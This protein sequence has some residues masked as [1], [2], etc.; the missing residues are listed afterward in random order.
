MA[1]IYGNDSNNAL[2]GA[3]QPDDI[4]GGGGDDTL[5]GGGGADTLFGGAGA[6]TMNGGQGADTLSGG[7]GNDT[8]DGAGEA[9]VM[10]GDSLGPGNWSF[11]VYDRNFSSANGQAFTFPGSGSTLR[12]EGVTADFN[13]DRMV[14]AARGTTGDQ[15]DFGIRLTT[16]Y[17]APSSGTY[18]F[19]LTSDDGSTMEIF[20]SAGNPV[21]WSNQTTGQTGLTYL[22]NDFHQP[23]ATRAGDVT[24]QAGQSYTIV[25]RTW[26]NAGQQILG[27]TVQNPGAT[28]PTNLAGDPNITGTFGSG[29][30]SMLGSAGNDTMFG[31][32]GDDTMFGGT[33]NDSMSGGDGNDSLSGDAGNDT[34][35][36][37][38]GA[39]TL[40]GGDGADSLWGGDGAD[41]LS[42]GLQDDTV[43][44]GAGDDTITGD[45]GADSLSGDAGSDSLSGGQGADTIFGGTG[46]DTVSGGTEND[47]IDGGDDND[48][49]SGDDGADTLAGGTG[50]D[51]LFGGTGADQLSGG[52]G[53]DSLDG[54]SG[55][56][57]LDGGSE[58]DTLRGGDDQDTLV[59]GSGDLLD[60]GEGGADADVASVADVLR[61][62]YGGGNNESGTITFTDNTTATFQ[63]IETLQ[64]G[65]RDGL[66][67]G[68]SGADTIGAGYADAQGD[69]ID[70]NDAIL[71]GE[72]GDDDRVFG[73]AGADSIASGAGND[74]VFGGTEGDTIDGGTG[75]DSLSG[76]AGADSLFG[77]D[78][79]DTLDGG[80]GADTLRGG[81]GGDL[82]RGGTQLDFVD[83]TGSDT[84]VNVN[85]AANTFSGGHATGDSSDGTV[86][87]IIG[88]GFGDSLTGADVQNFTGP[89]VFTTVIFG[90]G[91]ND[92]IDGRAGNDSLYGD[93]GDDILI[94]G[95]GADLLS[96]GADADTLDGGSEADLLQGGAG[97]DRLVGGSGADTL[98]GGDDRDL[99]VGGT[100]GDVVDG[101]EGG[102]DLDTLDL[103]L[104][105]LGKANTNIIYA[106]G[107]DEAGTVEILDG[108]GNVTGS[109]AFTGIERIVPCFTPGTMIST[110]AGDVP[111]ERLRPGDLVLT[112]DAGFR[113]LAWSGRRELSAAF[114]AAVPDLRPVTIAAGALG[115]GLP[116]A[117]LTVSPQHRVLVTGSRAEMLFGEHE[118]L[119]PAVHLVGRPGVTRGRAGGAV[120]YLHI[121][122]DR[123]EVVRSNGAWTESFQPAD[124]TLG[125]LD[126]AQRDELARLFPDMQGLGRFDAARRSLK[127]HEA[128][129]LLG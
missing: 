82:L 12:A 118:V 30:D 18:R 111:V 42:G 75:T 76:G 35:S 104:A 17:V 8:M 92:T 34:V 37:D 80:E 128:R 121:L 108:D 125:A 50:V 28:A 20:D 123:H 48:S 94:G 45:D 78:G 113:P 112:R 46:G 23:A 87:G 117:D 6:D 63:N 9:D 31:D 36:G 22:N 1:T 5:S 126:A 109:F 115:D 10:R 29:N 119:V 79:A 116:L 72:V 57:R 67:T 102:D 44:G 52:S 3:G 55:A 103:N 73:G 71:V 114:V 91:G 41:S 69:L 39:D 129:A 90:G 93:A 86:D 64:F 107:D 81:A 7:G 65:G 88:S 68:T 32:G 124:R 24:L 66:V 43:T 84:G 95:T 4:Y 54:G 33:E 98:Q 74:E 11:Q 13:V 59:A 61:V 40:S 58:A 110:A 16:G 100:A 49:L 2:S 21:V 15:N 60:G 51:T 27:A 96:G 56:D 85:L 77:N 101:G 19:G 14:N 99:F 70:G 47:S 106:G 83:Y 105:G 127:A 25:I 120:S 53:A 89:D 26:E 97:A 62:T 38:A 122:F